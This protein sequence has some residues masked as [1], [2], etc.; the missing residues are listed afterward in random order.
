MNLG[1]IGM[2]SV[3]LH[4]TAGSYGPANMVITPD[5]ME[6]MGKLLGANQQLQTSVENEAAEVG[7]RKG[8]F[9]CDITG[10]LSVNTLL[11]NHSMNTPRR[12]LCSIAEAYEHM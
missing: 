3:A 4:K 6:L 5:I 7:Q 1:E 8:Y 11:A 12:E 9:L 2:L 10:G